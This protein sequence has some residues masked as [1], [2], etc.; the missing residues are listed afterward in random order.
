[1]PDIPRKPRSELSVQ[2]LLPNLVTVGALCAGLTAIRFML[3]DRLELAVALIGLAAV[4]DGLDGRLA[5]LLNSESR[6]GAELD[7]LVDFL[8]FGVAPGLLIYVWALHDTQNAGWIAVMVYVVCCVLRLARFNVESRTDGDAH[9]SRFFTG[10]PAPAG[11]LLVMMPV[12]IGFIRPGNPPPH[13]ALVG[14]YT[15]FIGGLM[16]SRIPTFSFKSEKIYA[17]RARF[18]VVGFGVVIAALA[19]FPWETLV[20][21]DLIYLGSIVLSCRS[22][23]REGRSPEL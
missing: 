14:L 20:A 21:I 3:Q 12:F 13:D 4:L 23:I 19:S 8:N 1:M 10:V 17:D 15:V 9:P 6:I 2:Q 11:A 22:A 18:V 16:I 7:S 5:R